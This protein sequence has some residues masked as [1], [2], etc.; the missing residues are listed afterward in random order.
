LALLTEPN[1]LHAVTLDSITF[2]RS[3]SSVIATHNFSPDQRKRVSLFAVNLNLN[4]GEGSFA[5]TAQAED[6][7]QRVFPLTVAFV[8]K[9]PDFDWLTQVIVKLPDEI[10]NAGDV[11]V[12]LKV[13]NLQTNQ[14]LLV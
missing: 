3:P 14:A 5:I 10:A 9:V 6:S 12:S 2:Q 1:S 11:S 7:Q 4:T 8:G 13:G